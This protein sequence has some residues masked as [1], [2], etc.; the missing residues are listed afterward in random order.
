VRDRLDQ[1]NVTERVLFPGMDGI[2]AWLTRYYRPRARE[3]R[4]AGQ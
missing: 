2:S 4:D 1:V 3:A